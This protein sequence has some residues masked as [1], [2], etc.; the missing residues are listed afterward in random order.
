M[1]LLNVNFTIVF[2]INTLNKYDANL[3]IILR[4]AFLCDI[5]YRYLQ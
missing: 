1:F 3:Q 4:V 5:K 2:F